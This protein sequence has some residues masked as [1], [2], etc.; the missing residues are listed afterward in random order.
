MA[1][2]LKCKLPIFK[3]ERGNVKIA[4]NGFVHLDCDKSLAKQHGIAVAKLEPKLAPKSEPIEKVEFIEP[5]RRKKMKLPF[6][7]EEGYDEEV[8]PD[9]DEPEE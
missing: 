5:K 8:A 2:C 1:K 7:K 9:G 4:P 3:A 6:P